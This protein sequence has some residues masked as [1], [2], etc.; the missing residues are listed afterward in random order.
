MKKTLITLGAAL[1]G[2]TLLAQ[3]VVVKTVTNIVPTIV[4]V[5]VVRQ[6]IPVLRWQGVDAA[7]V[8]RQ[9][10]SITNADGSMVVPQGTFGA[11]LNGT[12][13]ISI[14]TTNGVPSLVSTVT[15]K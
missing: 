7:V 14:G 11:N 2:I 8:A 13:F 10:L 1:L 5:P 6:V 12:I 15:I 9:L 3:Q 4:T